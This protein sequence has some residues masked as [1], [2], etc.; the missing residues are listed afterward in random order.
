LIWL[1]LEKEAVE[2]D[3]S[4]GSEL[5]L[6]IIG[7]CTTH[8]GYSLLS[9]MLDGSIFDEQSSYDIDI[10]LYDMYVYTFKSKFIKSRVHQ[11]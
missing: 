9:S 6:S 5:K 11:G 2:C 8:L 1:K 10:Y 3:A 4:R 7:A